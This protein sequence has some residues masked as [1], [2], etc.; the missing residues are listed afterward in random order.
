MSIREHGGAV[1]YWV[2]ED[3]TPA[4]L[5]VDGKIL[6]MRKSRWQEWLDAKPE[7]LDSI[8]AWKTDTRPSLSAAITRTTRE[9]RRAV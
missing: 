2:H 3:G 4:V 6:T 8:A 9:A 7:L 5:C 1:R